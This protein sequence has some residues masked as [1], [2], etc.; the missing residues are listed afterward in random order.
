MLELGINSEENVLE[1]AMEESTY[2]LM[3]LGGWALHS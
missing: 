1:Q 2:H 3:V